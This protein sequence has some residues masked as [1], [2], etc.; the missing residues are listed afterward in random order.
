MPQPGEPVRPQPSAE[1]S[2]LDM[3]V[4]TLAGLEEGVRGPFLQRFFKTF[5]QIDLTESQS[6]DAWAKV[7]A[8][9]REFSESLGRRVSLKTALVDV[10]STTH[11]MRVPVVL[12]YDEYKKLQS[13]AA[14]D[15]LTGLYNRRLF[16]ETCERELTRSKRYNQ[17]LAFVI[18]DLRHLK[19]V[20][21][22]YGHPKGDE[23]LRLAANNL[24]KTLRASDFA[25][26][27]GGDEFALLLPQTDPE[28]AATLC[29]RVRSN[30]EA[31]VAPLQMKAGVTLDFGLAVH[32]RDA[33]SKETLIDVADKQLYAL[34]TA[35][36]SSRVIPME[37]PASSRPAP[38]ETSASPSTTI[39]PIVVPPITTAA[40]APAAT[41]AAAAPQQATHPRKWERVS[42]AG[43]KSYA[44]IDGSLRTAT[45]IDLSYGGVALVFDKGDDL[46]SQFSAVLHVP[47]LPPLRVSLRKAYANS[48]E[49]GRVR[50]GCAFVA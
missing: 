22:Q 16:D 46:P 35:T 17:Q 49:G 27:I 9:Q 4:E 41:H 23:V 29:R 6:L 2:F 13:Y 45:V 47:I 50:M 39:P 3:L 24:R 15:A 18:F 36:G 38:R 14:T 7:L 21:D 20:N 30:F 33:E 1:D 42:L 8:R 34:R 11:F 37:A 44:V 26:R 12:E 19:D 28:Q 43:T 40:N 48:A 25:F 32:P 10:L 5:T 31:E